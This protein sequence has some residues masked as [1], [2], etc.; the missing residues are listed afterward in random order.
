MNT[1]NPVKLTKSASENLPTAPSVFPPEHHLIVTT[2]TLVQCWDE[3]GI[4]PVF[5]SHSG[6]ILGAKESKDGSNQLAISDSQIVL[7]HNCQRNSAKTY[8]LKSTDDQVRQLEY[9]NESK[10]LLF[11]TSLQNAIQRYSVQ[12]SRLLDPISTHP[13]PPTVIAVSPTSHLLL[14]VSEQPPVVYLQNLRHGSAPL[15][16][17]PTA[18][19][20]PV[21]VAAFHPERP[22]I[23]LLGFADGTLAVYDANEVSRDAAAEKKSDF[24]KSGQQGEISCLKR[25]HRVIGQT[26]KFV[27]DHTW[28]TATDV[29]SRSQCITAAAFMPGSKTRIVSVGADGKCKLLDFQDGFTILRTWSIARP[30]TSISIL[31]VPLHRKV[32]N[33]GRIRD[34]IEQER[35]HTRAGTCTRLTENVVPPSRTIMAVGSID[36]KVFF[37]D[38]LGSKITEQQVDTNSNRVISVDWIQGRA[39]Q[40][41]P[42]SVDQTMTTNVQD[43]LP[44]L[45]GEGTMAHCK[46]Q[47]GSRKPA[48]A[49]LKRKRSGDAASENDYYMSIAAENMI[50]ESQM[51]ASAHE[52]SQNTS[53]DYM[54]LFS[55]VK[56][57]PLQANKHVSQDPLA[58]EKLKKTDAADQSHQPVRPYSDPTYP[59]RKPPVPPF[60][61]SFPEVKG[62]ENSESNKDLKH[63][64]P[65]NDFIKPVIDVVGSS[66]RRM[67]GA[68]ARDDSS[69]GSTVSKSSALPSSSSAEHSKILADLKRVESREQSKRNG[70]ALFAP[71]LKPVTKPTGYRKSTTLQNHEKSGIVGQSAEL[72][73][74]SNINGNDTSAEVN[75]NNKTADDIWADGLSPVKQSRQKR[76][77]QPPP[78]VQAPAIR[79]VATASGRFNDELT[80]PSQYPRLPFSEGRKSEIQDTENQKTVL[81]EMTANETA[82]RGLGMLQVSP[83]DLEKLSRTETLDGYPVKQ[84]DVDRST[85]PDIPRPDKGKAVIWNLEREE[86]SSGSQYSQ[87][88]QQTQGPKDDMEPETDT[89][90]YEDALTSGTAAAKAGEEATTHAC[91]CTQCPELRRELQGLKGEITQLRKELGLWKRAMAVKN[92]AP[93][94]SK[95][96][97]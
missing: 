53:L 47:S 46:A 73:T 67:P 63:S 75:D 88:K 26:Q 24:A 76:V 28:L 39:P 71:Y 49:G 11:T 21:T 74:Q 22:S 15:L 90:I 34:A 61:S 62:Q 16:L 6:G 68:F 42:Q 93:R 43:S 84:V 12:E 29:S 50:A 23:F 18:S 41:L 25:L 97:R 40:S 48:A 17:H 95:V 14:S 5:H 45:Q 79:P 96:V 64:S 56:K 36:G 94:K 4:A 51:P 37:F 57:S 35:R 58:N 27:G 82:G 86:P 13:S 83:G 55:P 91:H 33:D 77:R 32:Q 8:K 59:T 7:L 69:L 72:C 52:A 1:S 20:T 31:R 60:E 2:E 10:E 54:S 80:N 89:T 19:T 85:S 92:S 78:H 81:Q 38:N 44:N 3:Q 66:Y 87:H 9:S 30:G 65:H 70:I